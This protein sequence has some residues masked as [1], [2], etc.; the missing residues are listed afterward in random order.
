MYIQEI[1]TRIFFHLQDLVEGESWAWLL[2][3]LEI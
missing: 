1:L 3:Q 2:Q